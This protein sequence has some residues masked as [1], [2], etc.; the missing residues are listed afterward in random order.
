[1]NS[2][3]TRSNF[4]YYAPGCTDQEAL[5][6]SSPS[7]PCALSASSPNGDLFALLDG[8]DPGVLERSGAQLE[9]EFGSVLPVDA[10]TL[11]EGIAESFGE[12]AVGNA[13]GCLAEAV[14]DVEVRALGRQQLN[15]IVQ[16]LHGRAVQGSPAELSDGIH[17]SAP[18]DEE[19][20]RLDG[21]CPFF[22]PSY[23]QRLRAGAGGEHQHG[24]VV[25]GRN[26]YICPRI[27]HGPDGVKI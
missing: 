20:H 12:D 27:H 17:F 24:R 9:Q 15:N 22:G 11:I 3:Q 10:R 8:H 7:V 5:R 6:I 4:F 25:F 14:L 19:L 1:M 21:G 26:V 16:S 13:Q 23:P 2:V 18:L